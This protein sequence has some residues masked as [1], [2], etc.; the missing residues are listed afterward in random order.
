VTQTSGGQ[1]S[2]A[3]VQLG[4]ECGGMSIPI[5]DMTIDATGSLGQDSGTYSDSCG[6]Y[7]ASG[8]G[9]FFGRKLQAS[10]IYTSRT[11]YNMNVTF[12]LTR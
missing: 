3:P 12:N 2:I 9:G 11:C 4:G 5:G 1:V 6:L 10:F 8:S 7:N